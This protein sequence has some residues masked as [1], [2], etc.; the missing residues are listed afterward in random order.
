MRKILSFILIQ[1]ISFSSFAAIQL[2]ATRVIYNSDRSSASLA[3]NN[4]TEQNYMLQAWLENEDKMNKNTIPMQVIPPIMKIEAGRKASLR[5]IYSG[6]GLPDNQESL[7]WINIQEIPPA[8]KEANS[9]QIAVHS[10]LKLFYRPAS[11]KTNIEE[12]VEKLK[13]QQQGDKLT[14]IN[15]GP[16]YISLNRL[17]LANSDVY[18]DMISPFSERSFTLP[19]NQ[20]LDIET[21]FSYVNDFGG[22][23]EV[24]NIKQ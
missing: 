16:L 2:E 6:K 11:L 12:Q 14:I 3:L 4:S 20:P 23:T 15:S 5:F 22:I 17:H 1:F 24:N 13:W 18:L 9:L 19:T 7:F 10:R 8:P 21:T